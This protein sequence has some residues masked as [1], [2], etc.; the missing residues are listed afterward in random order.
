MKSTE[1]LQQEIATLRAIL[2]TTQLP[3]IDP[4]TDD[5]MGKS[6]PITERRLFDLVRYSRGAL[7]EDRLITLG[8]WTWLVT[9]ATPDIP[10]A[11]SPSR[12]RL[13]EYDQLVFRLT[14]C[15]HRNVQ[16]RDRLIGKLET[17]D[18]DMRLRETWFN[19]QCAMFERDKAGWLSEKEH[20]THALVVAEEALSRITTDYD[21]LH[22]T[23][24]A[25]ALYE[26]RAALDMK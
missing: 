7:L 19:E 24:F 9:G 6:I 2:E 15:E 12:N 25:P 13:E 3:V 18:A 20:M 14:Q 8:E 5:T 11:G 22:Q 23:G 1:Q 21:H 10:G 16:E 17:A 26:V 4:D